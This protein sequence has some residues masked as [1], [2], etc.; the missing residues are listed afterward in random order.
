MRSRNPD[1]KTEPVCLNHRNYAT[2]RHKQPLW[3]A[4]YDTPGSFRFALCCSTRGPIYPNNEHSHIHRQCPSSDLQVWI[5]HYRALCTV[6][7]TRYCTHAFMHHYAFLPATR[8]RT[9][10]KGTTASSRGVVTIGSA[11]HAHHAEH[12]E[13]FQ[14]REGK[15]GAAWTAKSAVARA[16]VFSNMKS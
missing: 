2:A 3:E 4:D 12:E 7:S 16:Y 8:Y 6:G 9:A 10:M 5:D 1:P 14:W 13:Y 11:K 15:H